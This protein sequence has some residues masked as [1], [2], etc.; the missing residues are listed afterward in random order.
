MI[1]TISN[2]IKENG[3]ISA[4]HCCGKC[5]W[6]VPILAGIDIV[7]LDAYAF[8]EHFSLFG[9][10]IEKLLQRGGKIAWGLVPTLDPEA[11]TQITLEDLIEKFQASINYLTKKGIDEKLII[12][13]SLVTPSCGAGALNIE[14]A[15][16]AMDLVFELSQELKKR[17]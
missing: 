2:V 4:I 5:D 7:N 13:N 1:E 16:K 14:L 12:D 17:L 15:E 9:K 10:A 11:L 8:G 3:G 6:T